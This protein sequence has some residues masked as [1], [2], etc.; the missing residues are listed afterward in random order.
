MIFVSLYHDDTIP[1]LLK[2]TVTPEQCLLTSRPNTGK[3]VGCGGPLSQ[4]AEDHG[5]GAGNR[6]MD[7]STAFSAAAENQCST[8]VV[9]EAENYLLKEDIRRS[10]DANVKQGVRFSYAQIS[11]D[12]DLVKFYT[13]LPQDKF[14]FLIRCLERYRMTYLYKWTVA[15]LSLADQVLLTLYKLRHNP[16][17]LDL[18]VRFGVSESCVANVFRTCLCALHQI[19]K[20]LH[21]TEMPSVEKNKTSLPACFAGFEGTRVILDCTEIECDVPRR[22]MAEQSQS[23]SHYKQRNTFKALVG[24]A[25]N[26]SV[27]FV[28]DL[29][30][31]SASDRDVTLRSGILEQLRPGD[32]IVADKG[33]T[34]RSILPPGVHLNVPPRLVNQ[35]F[36]PTENRLT[37]EIARARIHVERAI[38]RIKGFEIL[39]HVPHHLKPCITTIFQVCSLL[40]NL[41][42]P[43]IQE[44]AGSL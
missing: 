14:E 37:T 17:H 2:A 44:V 42:K 4:L 39:L 40:V 43:L 35:Q 22:D 15:V 5:A 1:L 16:K 29:F 7:T 11:G 13:G 25:P 31:G 33:F 6:S 34:I 23:Y 20:A 41:Q 36:T 12:P 27:V 28:S 38:E 24:V 26:G 18:A 3:V 8:C 32:F 30:L 10:K 9:T 19:L 21:G